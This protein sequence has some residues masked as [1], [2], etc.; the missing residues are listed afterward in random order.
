MQHYSA[1]KTIGQAFEG[2]FEAWFKQVMLSSRSALEI[3]LEVAQG[4]ARAC[5]S[6]LP[7]LE[8]SDMVLRWLLTKGSATCPRT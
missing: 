6:D 4:S 8:G 3:S 5:N 1:S 7:A 2:V